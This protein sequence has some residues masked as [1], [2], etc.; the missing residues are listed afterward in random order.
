M[1]WVINT[2]VQVIGHILGVTVCVCGLRVLHQMFF[3][4]AASQKWGAG[5]GRTTHPDKLFTASLHDTTV[6]QGRDG[7]M[8]GWMDGWKGG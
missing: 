5:Q 4:T 2:F 7:R 6:S 3:S 8:D 1:H